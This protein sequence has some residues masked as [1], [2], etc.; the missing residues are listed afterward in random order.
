MGQTRTPRADSVRNR[1]KILTAARDQISQHG[2]EVGMTEIAAAAGVAVGTLY[3]HFPTKADLVAAVIDEYVEQV[4]ADAEAALGRVVAGASA[5]T[6][7]T[8]FLERVVEVSASVNAVKAVAESLGADEGDPGAVRRSTQALGEM[9]HR[10]QEHGQLREDLTIDD[11]YLLVG[12][13]PM[14]MSSAA[15]K[16]WL[17][18][19]TTG[20]AAVGARRMP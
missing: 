15:R 3:R 4:A 10:A 8:G 5:Y 6:E 13:A 9:I 11:L 20:L 14:G 1:G 16:R 2:P 7:L 18:L 19:I 12:S 17:S